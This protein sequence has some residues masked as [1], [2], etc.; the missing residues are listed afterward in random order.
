MIA[1]SNFTNQ[2]DLIATYNH[3]NFV[4]S[5]VPVSFVNL[6]Q[7]RAIRLIDGRRPLGLDL[8]TLKFQV[9]YQDDQGALINQCITK[10]ELIDLLER[11]KDTPLLIGIEGCSGASYWT[12]FAEQLG[13][14]V[15]VMPGSMTQRFTKRRNK[16][17]V[18]DA[19]AIYLALFLPVIPECQTRT[20]EHLALSALIGEKETLLKTLNTQ[21]NKTRSLMIETGEYEL[22]I[23]DTNSALG[24]INTYFAN[25]QD[26]QDAHH[27]TIIAM[28]KL[29]ETI[30]FLAKQIDEIDIVCSEYMQNNIAARDLLTVPGIGPSTAVA[31][32]VSAPDIARFESARQFQAYFG[33][34]TRHC[35]SG[36][37]IVQS[38]MALN[39]NPAIK[40]MLYQ[41]ALSLIS[42]DYGQQ[43]ARSTWIEEVVFKNPRS[44]KKAP[45]KIAGKM[46]RTCF[47]VLKSGKPYD[48]MINGSLG[49]SKKKIHFKS[50]ANYKSPN[51]DAQLQQAYYDEVSGSWENA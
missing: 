20:E 10:G 2:R 12:R 37:K 46:I 41:G 45:I 23:R 6:T 43:S 13:H 17:D 33:L 25:H 28:G 27:Y 32:M 1:R 9:C 3:K 18:I 50:N 42:N 36:G 29:K 48:P 40:R 5:E 24:A 35:G 19:V 34:T 16:D 21:I 8:A 51:P 31:I 7:V 30:I 47:G 26:D 22:T 14:Q 4:Q 15:K 38:K 44:F 11:F 49:G 39:G